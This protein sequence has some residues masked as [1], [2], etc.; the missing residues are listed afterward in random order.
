M[1]WAKTLP[2]S[3]HRQIRAFNVLIL[4]KLM[5][6]QSISG[7]PDYSEIFPNRDQESAG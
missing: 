1:S 7:I 3:M 4:V 6:S 2:E 5:P